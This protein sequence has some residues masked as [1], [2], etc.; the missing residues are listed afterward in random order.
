MRLAAST[1]RVPASPLPGCEESSEEENERSEHKPGKQ[2][3]VDPGHLR[4]CKVDVRGR[5]SVHV[6]MD[7]PRHVENEGQTR[8][9]KPEYKQER[10]QEGLEHEVPPTLLWTPDTDLAKDAVFQGVESFDPQTVAPGRGRVEALFGPRI[11]VE[12][13]AFQAERRGQQGAHPDQPDQKNDQ[14]PRCG[15]EF[16]PC[17]RSAHVAHVEPQHRP[18]QVERVKF[19]SESLQRKRYHQRREHRREDQDP[20]RRRRQRLKVEFHGLAVRAV[21]VGVAGE[22][23]GRE[24]PAVEGIQ[25][26]ADMVRDEVLEKQPQIRDLE[27]APRS[28]VIPRHPDHRGEILDRVQRLLVSLEESPYALLGLPSRVL[29]GCR[30]LRVR[31]VLGGLRAGRLRRLTRVRRAFGG[32]GRRLWIP[33]LSPGYCNW[34]LFARSILASFQ[35]DLCLSPRDSGIS[36]SPDRTGPSLLNG[37]TAY[38]VIEVGGSEVHAVPP[39]GR[40]R[41]SCSRRGF[42]RPPSRGCGGDSS[43]ERDPRFVRASAR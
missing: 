37:G 34:I 10:E 2:S 12:E 18:N 22:R 19:V 33:L 15:A 20:I 38:E 21:G 23:S 30:A 28:L 11:Q 9:A 36:P 17:E 4:Q 7:V 35:R 25:A 32:I 26:P 24:Q 3:V 14:G 41:P 31:V 42:R 13:Y 27:V 5:S 6:E 8:H 29:L 1:A 43:Q 40:S 39:G 16:L